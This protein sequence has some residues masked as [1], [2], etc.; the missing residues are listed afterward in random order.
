MLST[1]RKLPIADPSTRDLEGSTLMGI[2]V[3]KLKSSIIPGN[4]KLIS[5]GLIKKRT[6]MTT[7]GRRGS[8]ARPAYAKARRDGS[9]A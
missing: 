5:G 3:K 4:A 8:G 2:G 7:S 6:R 1:G 9:S